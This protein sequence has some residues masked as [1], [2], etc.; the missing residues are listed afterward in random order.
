MLLRSIASQ[1]G[2]AL[3]YINSQNIRSRAASLNLNT[4]TNQT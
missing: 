4:P 2:N 1:N 3:V